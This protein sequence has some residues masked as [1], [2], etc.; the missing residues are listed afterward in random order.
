[1]LLQFA[2]D[3]CGIV[4][5]CQV[6]AVFKN[7]LVTFAAVGKTNLS[8]IYHNQQSYAIFFKAICRG[9]RDLFVS[10]A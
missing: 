4:Y 10:Y 5:F 1:M 3:I 2:C 6:C 7:I 9:C 8:V